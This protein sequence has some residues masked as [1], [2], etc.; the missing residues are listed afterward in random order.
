M[1]E[2][3]FDIHNLLFKLNELVIVNDGML[4][5]DLPIEKVNFSD[6]QMAF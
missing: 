3:A 4:D 5:I 2:Q 6:I 1:Y